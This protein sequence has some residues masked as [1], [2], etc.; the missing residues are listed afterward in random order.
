MKSYFCSNR[1]AS[2]SAG[3]QVMIL[4]IHYTT[5]ESAHVLEHVNVCHS[6]AVRVALRIPQSWAA[7]ADPSSTLLSLVSPRNALHWLYVIKRVSIRIASRLSGRNINFFCPSDQSSA[8]WTANDTISC[9]LRCFGQRSDSFSGTCWRTYGYVPVNKRICIERPRTVYSL[10]E[11]SRKGFFS[12]V[13]QGS[14]V[15]SSVYGLI[16][17]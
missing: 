6:W 11:T 16:P 9:P 2:F 4:S 10:V 17:H 8:K 7:L 12:T 15:S 3:S 14:S 1:Y 13:S 5:A